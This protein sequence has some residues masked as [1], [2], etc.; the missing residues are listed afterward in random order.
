MR[1]KFP[2]NC[3]RCGGHVDPGA[4]HFER[5]RGGWRV[6]HAECAIECRGTP[7]PQRDADALRRNQRL[8]EG[9]GKTAKR[10]RRYL[11]Q[12]Q[13]MPAAAREPV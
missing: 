4:G 9:T 2:G 10:A 12:R 7:D 8:A 11:R 13:E 3:Y 1:N 6:Q 5:F